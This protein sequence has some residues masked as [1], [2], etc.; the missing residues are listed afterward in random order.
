MLIRA[1]NQAVRAAGRNK[2]VICFSELQTCTNSVVGVK[3]A[4]K[5]KII[6]FYCF[7]W[8]K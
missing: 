8:K 6:F 5:K 2:A 3:V 1:D 7:L 4:N